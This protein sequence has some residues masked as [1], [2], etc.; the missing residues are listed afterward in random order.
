[1]C[2]ATWALK[3]AP[4]GLRL[5]GA[6]VGDGVDLVHGEAS[7]TCLADHAAVDLHPDDL[8]A[9]RGEQ[10]EELSASTAPVEDGGVLG[11]QVGIPFA[12]DCEDL[13]GTAAEPALEG[14]VV[15]EQV[16]RRRLGRGGRR[17]GGG[18]V[19]RRW[20]SRA[21]L[22]EATNRLVQLLRPPRHGVD[23]LP[24]LAHPGG[25]PREAGGRRELHTQLV[26]AA[27]QP[28]DLGLEQLEVGV[29]PQSLL[30]PVRGLAE[31]GELDAQL[32]NLAGQRLLALDLG[33][34]RPADHRVRSLPGEPADPRPGRA[35]GDPADGR[36]TRGSE[37]RSLHQRG[38]CELGRVL[39]VEGPGQCHQRPP[40]TI[41]DTISS[42]RCRWM[43][44]RR[45]SSSSSRSCRWLGYQIA[46]SPS[47]LMTS[48]A[49]AETLWAAS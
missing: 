30:V 37:G 41:E 29:A 13:L 45:E 4:E 18:P 31:P 44:P 6:H 3:T 24:Q 46:V 42:K 32:M 5:D 36:G 19:D 21:S 39:N 27:V 47:E 11:E 43:A 8:D 34:G 22:A 14:D 35:L 20:R 16:H 40:C 2:S 10:L 49:H 33:G 9:P 23:L 1:M 26:D 7:R 25:D 17:R 28:A 38:R 48:S 12:L 15:E